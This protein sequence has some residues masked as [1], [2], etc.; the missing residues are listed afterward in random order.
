M[1]TV[2]FE[3]QNMLVTVLGMDEVWA[4]KHSLTIPLS[5]VKMAVHDPKLAKKRFFAGLRITGTDIPG[6]IRAGTFYRRGKRIFWDVHHSDKAIVINLVNEK[7]NQLI[8]E[9]EDP[10]E[11]VGQILSRIS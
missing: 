9:V 1:T 7:Y 8:I 10:E 6:V 3:D 11:V 5:H 2:T 4:L